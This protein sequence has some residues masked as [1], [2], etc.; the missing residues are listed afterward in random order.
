MVH[1]K[2]I[3]SKGQWALVAATLVLLILLTEFV[4]RQEQAYQ[5]SIQQQ[6]LAQKGAQLR[7]VLESTLSSPLQL[8]QGLVAYVQAR[9]GVVQQSELD[10]LLPNLV[11]QSRFIR[12][13]GLAP[14]NRLRWLYPIAGNEQAIGL[15][16]PEVASQWPEIERTIRSRQ[17]VL[18]GPLTLA[19]GGRGLV[20][21]VP[22]YLPDGRYWGIV[23]TVLNVDAIWR[24]LRQH[25]QQLQ[26]HV[27]LQTNAASGAAPQWLFGEGVIAAPSLALPLSIAGTDWQLLVSA[28]VQVT[29]RHIWFRLLGYSLTLLLGGLLLV[30]LY[31]QQ[32]RQ[33]LSRFSSLREA[34][35]QAV[36]EHVAD[37]IVVLDARHQI[38]TVNQ[39]ALALTGYTAAQLL[40]QPYQKLLV[41]PPPLAPDGTVRQGELLRA[42]GERRDIEF[43]ATRVPFDSTALVVLLFR[44]VTERN[45]VD[46][47]KTEF[48][49]TVSHEL[50]T[51]LTA[52]SAALKLLTSGANPTLS[53]GTLS[54]P[55]Q[56]LLQVAT[57]NADQLLLLVND[58]LDLERLQSGKMQLRLQPVP[59]LAALEQ[60]LAR[61]S[62]LLQAKALQ[63][64]LQ[65]SLPTDCWL[66]L[67]AVRFQQVLANLL[68][69]AIRYSPQQGQLALQASLCPSVCKPALLRITLTDQGPGVPANFVPFLFDKFSQADSS[70]SRVQA[71]SGL[72]L[73][74]CR[75]LLALMQGEIRYENAPAGGACFIVEFRIPQQQE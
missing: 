56:Q 35:Y 23:S 34:Y 66:S 11:G 7:S 16:Y 71:G 53:A 51:P 8:S 14:D 9:N 70:D 52:L 61:H 60:A 46:R 44:D 50:R 10:F 24:Q 21:R 32:R 20:Y 38:S 33:Q 3:C 37:A 48:V 42:N 29:A 39:A 49:S 15:Y 31:V 5:H 62:P 28:Q 41:S 43:I 26:L 30:L 65:S 55:Q 68:A 74:I 1:N 18:A 2:L 36:L 73:A 54:A 63:L 6:D 72:G 75:Q 25:A 64:T 17:P 47:L 69:N 27:L 12:N 19:Q 59:V 67:D 4:V 57:A 40:A 13:M 58:I 22:L 45:R